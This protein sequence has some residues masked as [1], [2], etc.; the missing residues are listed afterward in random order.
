MN[1]KT[2]RYALITSVT[3]LVVILLSKKGIER[4]IQGESLEQ[5][6]TDLRFNEISADFTH[7]SD[8]EAALPFMALSAIDVDNDG[9]DE[10]FAGGGIGQQ[11]GLLSYDGSNLKST[12]YGKG[13]TKDDSDPTYGAAS[14]DATGDGLSDLFV[15][16]SSGLYLYE[17]TGS[18]FSGRQID[19][20]LDRK[21][22]PLSIALGDINHD[23]AVDVYL[24][25]YIRMEF[26]E[27]ETIFN[28]SDYGATNNLLLNNGDNTFTDITRESGIY[29]KHNSFLSIFLDLDDD[30]NSDLVV[31][32]DTG[33]PTI[34]KN[35]GDNTFTEVEL[36]VTFSYPMGIAVSDY[37]ND[38]MMDLYFSNVGNTLPR[39][40]LSGDLREDQTLN[41]DYILLENQGGFKFKDVAKERDAASLGFGWGLVSFDFNN[42]TRADYLISQN[43]IR[44]PGVR[45][46]GLFTLYP[47]RLL[48]QG[49]DGKFKPVEEVAGIA[50]QNF[51]VNMVVTDFNQDG[52]P[53]VV[54]GNLDSNL[55]GFINQG[56]SNHWLKVRVPDEPSSIGAIARLKTGSGKE[57]VNQ[58]YTSEGLGSDQGNELFFGLGEEDSLSNLTV[59]FQDGTKKIF[60]EPAVDTLIKARAGK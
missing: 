52:W 57:F 49:A 50:N 21:S 33:V 18:G 58:F 59:T 51:G 7:T 8:F 24:S 39:K 1:N 38:G 60:Q 5:G 16:R 41:M 44:F 3:L 15:V 47:G 11:D 31:A 19:F 12:S 42:D 2:I 14:I 10:I 48:Q 46:P 27:G 26:V 9:I 25:N 30:G 20:P 36:P 43:Y 45:L 56:G 35:N 17:N 55:R 22:L 23:G 28:D 13:I 32:H 34:Y 29:H 40:L 6:K 53:D 4:F 54:L 37:N